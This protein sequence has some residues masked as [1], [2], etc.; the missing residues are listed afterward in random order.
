MRRFEPARDL[1][2]HGC[3]R[4]GPAPCEA[5]A[6]RLAFEQFCDRVRPVARSRCREWPGFRM[7]QRGDARASRSKRATRRGRARSPG[8]TLS[9]TRGQRDARPIDFAHSAFAKLRET[10]YGPSLRPI[11]PPP[12]LWRDRAEARG[13]LRRERRRGRRRRSGWRSRRCRGACRARVPCRDWPHATTGHA[14][15]PEVLK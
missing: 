12:W 2:R 13:E 6:E 8:N 3:L 5:L 1:R 11:T 10:S 15:D 7:G 9:A 4:A 14:S